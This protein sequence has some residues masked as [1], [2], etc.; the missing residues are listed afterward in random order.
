MN[1]H[2]GVAPIFWN[3]ELSKDEKVCKI[4]TA[5]NSILYNNFT[6]HVKIMAGRATYT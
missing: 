1:F 6:M 5:L 2:E 4:E 3:K